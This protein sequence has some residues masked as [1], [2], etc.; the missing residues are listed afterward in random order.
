[1]QKIIIIV[2]LFIS[3]IFPQIEQPY[4]PITLISIPTAGTLPKGYFAFE[5]LFESDCHR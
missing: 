2:V 1:M 5:F 4:P 3:S